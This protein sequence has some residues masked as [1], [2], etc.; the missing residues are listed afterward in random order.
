MAKYRNACRKKK[1]NKSQLIIIIQH[2]QNGHF[3][4]DITKN[5]NKRYLLEGKIT[6]FN[7]SV[8]HSTFSFSR[9]KVGLIIFVCVTHLSSSLVVSPCT[10]NVRNGSLQFFLKIQIQLLLLSSLRLSKSDFEI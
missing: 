5:Q 3:N 9:W 4:S 7:L 2:Q 6:T 10:N 1:N 8:L